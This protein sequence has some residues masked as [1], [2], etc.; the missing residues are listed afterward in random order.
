MRAVAA[1]VA[2]AVA[3]GMLIGMNLSTPYYVDGAVPYANL[4]WQGERWQKLSDNS[5]W[6]SQDQGTITGAAGT[7]VFMSIIANPGYMNLPAGTYTFRNPDGAQVAFGTDAAGPNITT[8]AGSSYQTATSGTF[9]LAADSGLV[10]YCKGNRSDASGRLEVILPGHV[11]SWDAG[12]FFNS[13]Y[14]SYHQG[15]GTQVV[16]TMDLLNTNWNI[17]TDWADRSQP[18]K[19]HLH[20][21]AF[22]VPYEVVI[23]LSNRLGKPLWLNIPARVSDAFVTSLTTLLNST[24]DNSTL[25]VE[26]S[27]ESSFNDA[28]V[29]RMNSQIITHLEHTRRTVPVNAATGLFT[30]NAHGFANDTRWK[31]FVSL[32]NRQAQVYDVDYYTY[33]WGFT[34][35]YLKSISANTFELWT[36]AG[37]TGTKMVLPTGCTH[38]ML[39]QTDEAGKTEDLHGF[40]AKRS[41]AIWDI[42]DA[43]LPA[44]TVKAVLGSQHAAPSVTTALLANA[45]YAA[46]VDYVA[47]AP[48]FYGT[49]MGGQVVRTSNTF[50]P[51]VWTSSEAQVTCYFGVYPQGTTPTDAQLKSGTGG[52]VVAHGSFTQAYTGN[53][54]ATGSAETVVNGTTYACWFGVLGADGYFWKWSQDIAAAN[55]SDTIDVLDDYANQ[56]LRA[57]IDY[58]VT[59][60]LYDLA[61]EHLTII[62]AAKPT[63][64]LVAYEGGNHQN[65]SRP[66]AIDA[67]WELWWES[68]DGVDVLKHHQYHAAAAGYELFCFF[69]D[70][71]TAGPWGLADNTYDTSDLR[72]Q[73]MSA[74][75][76]RVPIQTTVDVANA[77]ATPITADPGSFPYTAHTFA[78]AGLTYTLICGD[79]D[80]NFS[81]SGA[82]VSMANDTGVTWANLSTKTLKFYATDGETDSFFDLTIAVGAEAWHES[83]DKLSLD[84]TAQA[85]TA[86]LTPTIGG[87][88][89]PVGAQGTLA[90]GMLDTSGGSEYSRDVGM[91]GNINL[92]TD[93]AAFF[94]VVDRDGAPNDVDLLKFGDTIPIALYA[95]GGASA[96]RCAWPSGEEYYLTTGWNNAKAVIWVHFDPVNDLVTVGYNQNTASSVAFSTWPASN[97]SRWVTIHAQGQKV[98]SMRALSRAG[99]TVANVKAQVAKMQTL[100]SIA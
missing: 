67:W 41:K 54:Y 64:G 93:P 72:Y 79:E 10:V 11:T 48:Y 9:T 20:G 91:S 66:T 3:S 13:A 17:A 34:E 28:S 24:Y 26:Y 37:G 69:T 63:A 90:S 32:Q 86:S 98:G 6:P 73:G 25:Y 76:G 29:F 2:A 8:S 80:G 44:N 77:T 33:A 94:V 87:A 16:R 31:T 51:K 43:G 22:G 15:L 1:A 99:L 49:Q 68:A 40:L 35:F 57:K 46:R 70:Q 59:R 50:T 92:Q 12:D 65:D 4:M 61:Q 56:S 78:N 75:A 21:A 47:V 18:S 82:V 96:W 100:H 19:T 45:T 88:L 23:A 5:F 58:V 39:I 7:D 36:G 30:L 84:M 85:S 71:E 74:F 55:V 53:S 95:G 14:I 83:D 81:V 60:N 27:N 89:N 97:L 62:H 42:M 38:M 52:S